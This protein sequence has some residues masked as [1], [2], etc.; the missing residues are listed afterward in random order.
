[1]LFD[2]ALFLNHNT[3]SQEGKAKG[4]DIFGALT[5]GW[6]ISIFSFATFKSPVSITGFFFS[7]SCF[8]MPPLEH[9]HRWSEMK[10]IS[11]RGRR[12]WFHEEP[13]PSCN[14]KY[15]GWTWNTTFR[16]F[17]ISM[18]YLT[19]WISSC[20][21]LR[22]VGTRG[23][24]RIT[25]MNLLSAGSQFCVR[26]SW[27]SYKNQHSILLI[28]WMPLMDLHANTDKVEHKILE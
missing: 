14:F 17:S 4:R 20:T 1:M 19:L 15:E 11:N 21:K 5:A 2:M 25:F 28:L 22:S 23:I 18:Y 7:S 6:C 26:Y 12:T 13:F 24:Q 3:S 27:Q 8:T 16:K 10:T 9:I